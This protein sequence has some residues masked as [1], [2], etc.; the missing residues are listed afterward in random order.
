L[1]SPHGSRHAGEALS[2]I[3]PAQQVSTMTTSSARKSASHALLG[4]TLAGSVA[5]TAP[6]FAMTEL[7]QGYALV[8]SAPPTA[9]KIPPPAEPAPPVDKQA[10]NADARH[11]E[12]KCGADAAAGQPPAPTDKADAKDAGTAADKGMEGK[13]GE[14]KCGAGI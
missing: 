6:A 10:A 12:G 8:A 1:V 11:A 4:A 2:W 9:G 7:G 13:C 14:G 5:L 3:A